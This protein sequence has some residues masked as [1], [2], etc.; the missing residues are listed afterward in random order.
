MKRELKQ[1]VTAQNEGILA[2]IAE[3]IPMKREL[4]LTLQRSVHWMILERAS[5]WAV[6]SSSALTS[7]GSPTAISAQKSETSWK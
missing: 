1:Y 2:R 4:K 5:A 3:P 6:W 7:G